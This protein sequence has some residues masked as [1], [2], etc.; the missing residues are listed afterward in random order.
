MMATVRV[1]Q[2]L[3][4]NRQKVGESVEN[5]T[6][7]VSFVTAVPSSLSDTGRMSNT[8]DTATTAPNID[9]DRGSYS[10]RCPDMPSVINVD[11]LYAEAGLTGHHPI[12]MIV[13]AYIT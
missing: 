6:D 12:Y 9:H 5:A 2:L 10:G 11:I 8:T 4:L 1:V 13:G 7:L 3:S